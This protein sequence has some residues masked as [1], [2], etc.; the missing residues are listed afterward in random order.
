MSILNWFL[1]GARVLQFSTRAPSMSWY[2]QHQCLL[3]DEFQQKSGLMAATY[4][5][6]V[7]LGSLGQQHALG[8]Q[9]LVV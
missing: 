2:V 9:M 3:G 8:L 4:T 5:I 7:C 1:L 6:A